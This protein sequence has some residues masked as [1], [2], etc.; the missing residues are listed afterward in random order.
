[1][2]NEYLHPFL[3]V[4]FCEALFFYKKKKN[5]PLVLSEIGMLFLYEFRF[6][7]LCSLQETLSCA[8]Y[9]WQCTDAGQHLAIF[10]NMQAV[11]PA[12]TL[13]LEKQTFLISHFNLS[14]FFFTKC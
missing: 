10:T 14:I 5:V 7:S 1:M 8:P 2:A 6:F 13:R 9:F 4:P 12:V 11:V 3:G